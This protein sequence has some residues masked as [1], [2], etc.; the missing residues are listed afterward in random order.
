MPPLRVGDRIKLGTGPL[1]MLVV[2][3]VKRRTNATQRKRYYLQGRRYWPELGGE[4]GW[5]DWER[6][7]QWLAGGKG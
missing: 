5:L 7:R 6:L 3:E 2:M 4:S 1:G